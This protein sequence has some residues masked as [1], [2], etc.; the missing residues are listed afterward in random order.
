MMLSYQIHQISQVYKFLF[1][2]LILMDQT[3]IEFHQI[4]V[5]H[6]YQIP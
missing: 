6:I 5:V 2:E 1:E 4:L 3:L